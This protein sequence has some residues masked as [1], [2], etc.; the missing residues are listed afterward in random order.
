MAGSKAAGDCAWTV[1]LARL[2]A[3][4]FAAPPATIETVAAFDSQ[5]HNDL[6]DLL[7]GL[8]ITMGRDDLREGEGLCDHRPQ[9]A[10]GESVEDQLS[11]AR[12]ALG[13]VPDRRGHPAS[14]AQT[15]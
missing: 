9:V 15:L 12:E 13:P 8:E 11:V 3:R 4:W 5:R 2:T 7:I 6:A 14:D 10:G 1:R